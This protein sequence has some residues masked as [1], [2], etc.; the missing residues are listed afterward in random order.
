MP[1]IQQFDAGDLAIRP[2]ELG[3]ETTARAAMRLGALGD[4]VAQSY[5]QTGQIIGRAVDTA[6]AVA[7]QHEDHAQISRG[8][9]GFSD[10]LNNVND[11]WNA[12][13]KTADPNDPSVAA[14]FREEQLE[15]ALENFQAGFTTEN[16]QRWAEDQVDRLRDHMVEKTSADMSTLAGI[17]AVQNTTDTIN[18]LGNATFNDP[19]SLDFSR[20]TLKQSVSAIADLS[21]HD[22]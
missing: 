2:D 11:Q 18:K 5:D 3:V 13:A 7:V 22:A 1:N 14:K 8:A 4:Q 16:S 10:L 20:D 12:I 17:A 6:G 15:P 19:S 9:K 21:D